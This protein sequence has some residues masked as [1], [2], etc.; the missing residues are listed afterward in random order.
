MKRVLV[1]GASGFI[2][3]HTLPALAL[4]GFEVHAVSS[5]PRP[6]P[7]ADAR[8]HRSDLLRGADVR[9]LMDSVQP[10]HL[11]HLA[12]F[13]V[14]GQFWTSPENLRW[15]QASLELLSVFESVGGRR[16]VAAGSCA[17]YEW[18]DVDC[19]EHDTPLRPATLYGTCKHA[20]HLVMEKFADRRLSTA[21]GRVF[22]LYGPH[23]HPDRLVPSVICSLLDGRPAQCTLGTQVRDFLHVADVAG[24]FVALLDSPVGG[25][26]N[27]ASGTPVSIANL[28]STI[29]RQ[30]GA[31]SLVRLGARPL[32][33]H[34][35]PR[36]TARVARLRDEVGWTPTI[37]LESGLEQTTE[38]WRSARSRHQTD[39]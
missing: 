23:E 15:V 22:H 7:A 27:I 37:S 16:L 18:S 8:W 36:L 31:E 32:P 26:V 1:T 33:A 19:D 34:E 25:G 6:S 2:G 9:Q 13:A 21:W 29:G 5:Q 3:R 14:P 4:R 35:Q 11:L 39:A 17:E 20:L 30:M 12:W 24:A 28:V 38:W 10:T